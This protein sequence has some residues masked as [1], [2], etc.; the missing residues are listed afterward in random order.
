MS[1]IVVIESVFSING[2]GRAS[3]EAML[4]TDI[5]V[6]LGFTVFTCI[7]VVLASLIAD[8]LYAFADPRVR[9]Y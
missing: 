7:V 4:Q 5:P 1:G 2:I 6:A 9:L 3:A 8:V